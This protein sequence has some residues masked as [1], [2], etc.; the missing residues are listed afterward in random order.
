MFLIIEFCMALALIGL[1]CV[2]PSLG[3]AWFE[4]VELF[5]GR[6]ARNRAGAVLVVGVL[7]LCV[8]AAV[9]PV[10]PIPG[11]RVQDEYSYLLAGDT[12]AHGRL[13]NPTHPMWVH[14]ETFHVIQQPSY[15]SMYPPAQG[16]IL[17]L[18][19][20]VFGDPFWG[21][22]LSLGIMCASMCWMLQAWLP[23][24]WA[25][26][27]GL[28]VIVRLAAFSYWGN[29]YWGGAM[30]ATGGALVLGALPRLQQS[31]RARDAVAMALG[32]AVLANSRPYEGLI[33]SI[34]IMAAL[35]IWML[36]EN[37]SSLPRTLKQVVAPLVLVL[38]IAGVATGYYFWRVTGSP[39]R[40]PYQVNRETYAV[41]PYFLWQHLRPEPV[42]HHEVMRDFY[43]LWEAQEFNAVRT[44]HGFVVASLGKIN[45]LWLFYLGPI[46]VMVLLSALATAPYGLSWKQVNSRTRFLLKAAA[47]SLAGLLVEVYFRPHYAAPMTGLIVVLALQAMRYLARWQWRNKPAG[48]AMVR[49]MCTACFI[50]LIL[51]AAASPLHLSIRPVLSHA[52]YSEEEPNTERAEV[53]ARLQSLPGKQLAIVHYSPW[54]NLHDE[55]VNNL[56]D[57]D[58]SKVVWARDMDPEK[59]SE[60]IKIFQRPEGVAGH[61][62]KRSRQRG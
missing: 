32:L 42:Y 45:M 28:L 12:F 19:K 26:L 1:A 58:G 16:L 17:G 53:L 6:L 8:R 41:A 38:M 40:M 34:P 13:T 51:R 22:W 49:A 56:A 52:W 35:I 3:H 57:I 4:R 46:F 11:P 61:N 60:L 54:H 39:F 15:A 43:L 29:S 20:S 31:Q 55:W 30:A 59:N 48:L 33:F 27:G 23:E 7:A 10:E 21:M 5:F 36:R 24:G 14:F 62:R 25:L 9:L 44:P 2:F 50:L 18:G 37:R 47:F